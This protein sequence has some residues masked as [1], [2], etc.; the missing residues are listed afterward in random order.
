LAP[1]RAEELCL[2][3]PNLNQPARRFAFPGA[4][5][6]PGVHEARKLRR[7]GNYTFHSGA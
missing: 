4:S 3:S 6:K 7:R 2:L 1:I 5:T